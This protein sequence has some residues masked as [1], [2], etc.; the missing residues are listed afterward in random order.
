MLQ[1]FE[2]VIVKPTIDSGSGCNIQL[3]Q[4]KNDYYVNENREL[5]SL[6]YLKDNYTNNYNIQLYIEQH[7]YFRQFNNTSL[8][9]VRMLTYRSV[10]DNKVHILGA[11]I[12]MGEA[13][14]VVDNYTIGGIA[15][16]VKSDGSPNDFA[17]DKY[18]NR[19]YQNLNKTLYFKN[20]DLVYKYD[21]LSD[22]AIEI[23]SKNYYHRLI[24]LDLC[25]D[26]NDQIRIIEI[27]NSNI[28]I[29]FFQFQLGPVF[30]E[31]TDE[32]IDY[33]SQNKKSICLDYYSK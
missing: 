31:F 3:F 18:G 27:N 7:P 20:I 19:Y 33:C 26:E 24:S 32:I 30:G 23:A 5:L 17:V 25:V 8:N 9:S 14:S 1:T 10:K 16:G 13:G 2:K 21:K 22:I 12:R 28:E 29:N 11:V 6:D 15:L 4:K